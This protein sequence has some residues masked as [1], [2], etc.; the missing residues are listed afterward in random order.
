MNNEQYTI[1]ESIYKEPQCWRVTFD[2]LTHDLGAEIWV[3]RG[4]FGC[5]P[6]YCTAYGMFQ[7]L[8]LWKAFQ[9]WSHNAT[10][11]MLSNKN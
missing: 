3:S 5:T 8:K 7:R 6:R 1:L 10:P 2:F 9:W 4:R 11:K